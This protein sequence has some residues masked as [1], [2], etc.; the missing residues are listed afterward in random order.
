MTISFVEK[1]NCYWP[2][3]DTKPE[4]NYRY[5]QDHLKDMEYAISKC[6]DKGLAIQAGGHVGF[7]PIKLSLNFG[8]VMT[9][10]PE[11]DL[12]DCLQKNTRYLTNIVALPSAL[13]DKRHYSH[14]KRSGS[15]GK[16]V[17]EADGADIPIHV[18]SIDSLKIRQRVCAI[19]LDVEH[20]EAKV[21]DGALQTIKRDRPVIQVEEL[22]KQD[23]DDVWSLLKLLNYTMDIKQGKDRIY[24]P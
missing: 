12:Y 5:I 21:I 1:F 24:L 2:D 9:F 17:V 11:P 8:Q 16:N 3:W 19:F 18:A 20:Y 6:P 22:N 7:W 14:I 13:G 4:Q 23:Q 15:S 10:E